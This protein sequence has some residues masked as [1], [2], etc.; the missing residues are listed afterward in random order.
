R[1]SS[2]QP[3][4][5]ATSASYANSG[6]TTSCSSSKPCLVA[7]AAFPSN[8]SSQ[9]GYLVVSFYRSS[10]NTN[11]SGTLLGSVTSPSFSVPSGSSATWSKTVAYQCRS[12]SSTTAYFWTKAQFRNS[13]LTVSSD[14]PTPS[15]TLGRA[16]CAS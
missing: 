12:V 3:S 16:G 14:T 15:I 1:I 13:S 4:W 2:S 5:V 7:T 9:T 6:G 11:G 8:G 10:T